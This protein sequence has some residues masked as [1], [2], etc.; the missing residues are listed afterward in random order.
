MVFFMFFFCR[1]CPQNWDHRMWFLCYEWGRDYS[2]VFPQDHYHYIQ[3]ISI[4][5]W[6]VV[7]TPL[8][9]MK[10]S[11]DEDSNPSHMGKEKMATKPPTSHYIQYISIR[12]HD[13]FILSQHFRSIFP[14]RDGQG[15]P[16]PP[17]MRVSS[18]LR[19][20]FWAGTT[21]PVVSTCFNQPEGAR[22]TFTK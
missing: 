4:K 21:P 5:F 17:R 6:L 19:T 9:N 20:L 8:K 2:N 13:I 18:A 15:I 7:S 3:Y 10:V 16:A 11:W 12:F 1:E 14:A 22:G